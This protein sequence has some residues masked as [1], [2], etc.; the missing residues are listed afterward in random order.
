MSSVNRAANHFPQG[1]GLF[2]FSTTVSRTST[3][4]SPEPDPRLE[5]KIFSPTREILPLYF[6]YL[7]RHQFSEAAKVLSLAAV[8][9]LTEFLFL[10][11]IYSNSNHN[12]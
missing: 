6:C 1:S 10:R 9:T 11:K 7:E 5:P 12:D 4:T 3:P 8:R 2:T